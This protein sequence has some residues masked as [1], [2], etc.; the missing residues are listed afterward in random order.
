MAASSTFA[1][2]FSVLLVENGYLEEDVRRYV[3]VAE[4]QFGGYSLVFIDFPLS[5]LKWF[6]DLIETL[7][8]IFSTTKECKSLW[9]K[10]S[11]RAPSQCSA[12]CL[13]II[14][15]TWKL[16]SENIRTVVDSQ[17]GFLCFVKWY[18]DPDQC[19]IP[20]GANFDIGGTFC[21][22]DSFHEKVLLVSTKSRPKFFNFPGGR[23]D[24][25][26]D[27][28][29]MDTS[30]RELCEEVYSG[31][32]TIR[33]VPGSKI[34]GIMHFPKNQF[35][36]SVNLICAN[37]VPHFSEKD[38]VISDE[39]QVAEWVPISSL[40]LDDDISQS[41]TFNGRTVGGEIR[42]IVRKIRD[43]WEQDALLNGFEPILDRGFLTLFC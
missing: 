7:D 35:A 29:I 33:Q 23:H 25:K 18:G 27:N 8:T 11:N 1:T 14:P 41:L 4:D 9:V 36:P 16:G 42:A 24:R 39:L 19:E 30:L 38:C 15:S 26:Y 28:S 40:N 2:R 31:D 37:V 13:G 10:F 3:D 21:L 32:C 5:M 6:Q 12:A 43:S 22:I 20:E 17:K 34:V